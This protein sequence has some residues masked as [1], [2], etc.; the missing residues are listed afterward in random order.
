VIPLIGTILLWA[1]V[2]FMVVASVGILRL[3]DFYSRLHAAS[4]TETLGMVLVMLGLGLHEG[5][6]LVMVKLLMAS[7]FVFLASP[8]SAHLLAR[9]AAR[10]GQQPWTRPS[11][12][13]RADGDSGEATD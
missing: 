11:A 3:P 4:K 12:R 1:G 5:M 13:P 9:A 2:F 6:S 7:I 10:L 8:T